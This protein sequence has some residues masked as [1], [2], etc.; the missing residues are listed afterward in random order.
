[1]PNNST[2]PITSLI[3]PEEKK[4]ARVLRTAM[5]GSLLST[6]YLTAAIQQNEFA[7]VQQTR[8]GSSQ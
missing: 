8:A 2:S 1:M 4:F 5:I 7:V 3:V 6:H